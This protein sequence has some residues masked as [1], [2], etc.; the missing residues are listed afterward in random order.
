MFIPI[1]TRIPRKISSDRSAT[2]LE[3][4]V[5]QRGFFFFLLNQILIE[6][7]TTCGYLSHYLMTMIFNNDDNYACKSVEKLG[8]GSS[9]SMLRRVL[10]MRH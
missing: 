10:R 3:F 8:G 6:T 4:F 5:L 1:E 2:L 9:L 7:R